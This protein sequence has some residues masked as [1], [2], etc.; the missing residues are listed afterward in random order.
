MLTVVI[1]VGPDKVYLRYLE[2]CVES[3]SKQERAAFEILIMDD[4]AHLKGTKLF[5][6][7]E[8][9]HPNVHIRKTAWLSG[10]A[11]SFNFGV[12]LAQNELVIMLGSDDRLQPWAVEDC[13]KSY[14][15]HRDPLG[16][17]WMDVEYSHG[18]TQ[19]LPCNA[20][21]VTKTMW[22]AL[23][24]FPPESACGAMDTVIMSVMATHPEAGHLIKVE[25]DEPP[26]WY[27]AHD[28]TYSRR[29]GSKLAGASKIVRDYYTENWSKPTWPKRE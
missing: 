16:Y 25:S 14:R 20:A 27:R 8:S 13:I 28:E 24:G 22:R 17:Y 18:E 2:E 5:E 6:S 12:A 1:P 9:M 19:S 3:V 10:V 4:Q 23:G 7:I 26:Y 11:H 15:Q 29:I 21:M